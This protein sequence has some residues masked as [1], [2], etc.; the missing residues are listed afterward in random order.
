MWNPKL[1]REAVYHV[2]KRDWESAHKVDEERGQAI[3]ESFFVSVLS[4]L[5]YESS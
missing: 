2:P 3:F 4:I 1:H 5:G